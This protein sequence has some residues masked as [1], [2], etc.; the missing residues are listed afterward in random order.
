[1]T[2]ITM[3]GQ[4]AKQASLAIAP[5]STQ[6]KNRFLSTLAKALVDDT[7]TLL[8]ANQKDL[9]NAKEHGISDIMTDR[10]RLTAERIEAIAQGVQQVADLADPIGQVIKGYTNLDGLKILQKRVPLGVIAM[11]F[12][13][14]PNVSVDAFSL[15]FKT[16]NA[17]ILRGGKDALYSNKALVK[18]IRQ[19]LEESGITPDAV[20]LVEDPSHAVAE[21]LMQATDYV[22]VL[23]PRGGAK[24]IQTV[25]E[26][27]KVP[28]IETGVGNVHIYV[29]AQ[30][31][32]DMATK[33]VINAKTKR[34]SVC[35]AA[36]GLVIHEAVAARFIPMLEKAINQV[37]PVEW[38]VDDKALP[39][40]EQAMPAKAEDF[41]TE[42]LDY[43]MSVK[44]V[45]SLE[46]AISWINQHTSH[47]SEAIITRDIKAAETFQDL[48]DAAAVYVNA[49]TRFTDGFVFGLGAEIGISTQKMH[50]R[51]PMGLE[52]LT[53]SKFYINGDG[54][55]RK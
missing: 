46:E 3:L 48:V 18:L 45:S 28:V 26:K 36:E 24:L 38:R 29:D 1:M 50:A 15:A 7:Q 16:N 22:D 53:S 32:L 2:D 6:I 23:I 5:L 25:K 37:Q 17:I 21:E 8:A 34:P 39:L 11:I 51:G 4:R 9:A 30:A 49:S 43:I 55:I 19:S 54:H 13:S 52:A 35:N 42:F 44:I 20:Q 14:R 33:I 47:H 31:D 10:L 27:A 12:E 41:E 40:F